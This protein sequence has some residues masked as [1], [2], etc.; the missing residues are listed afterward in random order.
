MAPIYATPGPQNKQ[1]HARLPAQ[2]VQSHPAIQLL[3]AKAPRPTV[4]V[5]NVFLHERFEKIM[6]WSHHVQTLAYMQAR[7]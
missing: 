7:M 5:C 2:I 3:P 1:G 4:T 6:C